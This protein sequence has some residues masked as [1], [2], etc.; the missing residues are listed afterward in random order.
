VIDETEWRRACADMTDFEHATAIYQ[1]HDYGA[2]L[3]DKAHRWLA[4]EEEQ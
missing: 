1:A 2:H 3:G 4:R